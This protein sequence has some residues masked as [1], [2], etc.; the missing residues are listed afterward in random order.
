MHLCVTNNSSKTSNFAHDKH[1]TLHRCTLHV[2]CVGTSRILGFC[3]TW[4]RF[5][6]KKTFVENG[7]N[8]SYVCMYVCL[9][10]HKRAHL[11][12]A[13]CTHICTH[14]T[15]HAHTPHTT[16]TAHHTPHTRHAHTTHTPRT[17]HITQAGSDDRSTLRFSPFR[18]IAFAL[19]ETPAQS[20]FT[21]INSKT[22]NTK[23]IKQF[24][25]LL[26]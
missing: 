23:H 22:K 17:P 8:V 16:H 25:K 1:F 4:D 20:E 26:H 3:Y 15:T 9:H 12:H 14:C 24:I 11:P 7:L 5:C 10:T 13:H 6:D 19:P 18:E 21:R 2:V